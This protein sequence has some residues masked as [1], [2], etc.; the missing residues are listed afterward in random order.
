MSAFKHLSINQVKE[1]VDNNTAQLIDVRDQRSYQESH[2]VE[3]V[4]LNGETVHDF[5]KSA[6]KN[7]PLICYCYHGHSSQSAATFFA[8]QGFKDVYSMDGGYEQWKTT[9]GT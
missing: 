6:D 9:Y 8:E 2:I 3:A 4:N 1:F 7:K 5:V